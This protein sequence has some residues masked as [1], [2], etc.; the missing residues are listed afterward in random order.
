MPRH[1]NA[2]I[3]H[4]PTT[5]PTAARIAVAADQVPMAR[6]RSPASNSAEMMARLP[7]TS[8]AAP[9]P[10]TPRATISGV[11][12]RDRPQASDAAPNST[13][14]AANTRRRPKRS[15]SAPP[16]RIRADRSRA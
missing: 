8:S 4:P 6:P 15:P 7:G 5:G 3:S 12:P 2:S 10:W 9:I 16:T 13:T 11:A 14:P 1:E